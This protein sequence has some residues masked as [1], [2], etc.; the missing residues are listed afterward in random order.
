M[1][2]VH[3]LPPGPR[4]GLDGRININARG[5]RAFVGGDSSYRRAILA[6]AGA[7]YN[8]DPDEVPG[9]PQESMFNAMRGAHGMPYD[10]TRH[11][12]S[13]VMFGSEAHR[14]DNNGMPAA[15]VGEYVATGWFAD[16]IVDAAN[17]ALN[18]HPGRTARVQ[19]RLDVVILTGSAAAPGVPHYNPPLARINGVLKRVPRFIAVD[20]ETVQNLPGAIRAWSDRAS[21]EFARIIDDLPTNDSCRVMTHMLAAYVWATPV[22]SPRLRGRGLEAVGG[23][24]PKAAVYKIVSAETTALHASSDHGVLHGE[25]VLPP[26]LLLSKGLVM[27]NPL[28]TDTMC[29]VRAICMALDPRVYTRSDVYLPT[30]LEN[31]LQGATAKLHQAKKMASEVGL[32]ADLLHKRKAVVVRWE[33]EIASLQVAVNEAKR[34]ETERGYPTDLRPFDVRSRYVSVETELRKAINGVHAKMCFMNP[35]FR[36]RFDVDDVAVGML[37]AA[38]APS[39]HLQ[40]WGVGGADKICLLHPARVTLEHLRQGHRLVNLFI[41]YNHAS[42]IRSI[43]A[44]CNHR[45]V[46]LD[47]GTRVGKASSRVFCSMCG[48]HLNTGTIGS[49]WDIYNHQVRGCPSTAVLEFPL[50][51]SYGD[52]V[53]LGKRARIAQER[54]L[55]FAA[56][57]VSDTDASITFRS[58]DVDAVSLPFEHKWI[59]FHLAPPP[60]ER[61]CVRSGCNEFVSSPAKGSAVRQALYFMCNVRSVDGLLSE[62]HKVTPKRF[63]VD[64]VPLTPE[65][66]CHSCHLPVNGPSVWEFQAAQT[67]EYRDDGF[68]FDDY[69]G[70]EDAR[71]VAGAVDEE[72]VA[73]ADVSDVSSAPVRAPYV[74]HHCHA[75]GRVRLAHSDCNVLIIQ[76]CNR[77]VVEM[78]SRA[79]LAAIVEETC[80]RAFMDT[81]SSNTRPPE[82]SKRDGLVSRV[83]VSVRGSP[84]VASS[85][86]R[87]EWVRARVAKG[88][89][90]TV[91]LEESKSLTVPRVLTLVFRVS[92]T[93][94]EP[95]DGIIGGAK[96]THHPTDQVDMLA[97]TLLQK[98]EL[99]FARTKLWMLAFE[100]LTAYGCGCLYN[101]LHLSLAPGVTPTSFVNPDS[102]DSIG[103]MTRGGRILVG[104]RAEWFPCDYEDL[105]KRRLYFDLTSAYPAVLKQFKFPLLCHLDARAHDFSSN[106]EDGLAFVRS[107]DLHSDFVHRMEIEGYFPPELHASL[108]DFC[109]VYQRLEVFGRNMSAFQRCFMAT[110]SE[111]SVGVKNV[112][113]LFPVKDW[114]VFLRRAKILDSMGFVFTRIGVVWSTPAS[115]WARPFATMQEERRR[116]AYKSKV[117]PHMYTPAQRAELKCV[118]AVTKMVCNSVIGTFAKDN[119]RFTRLVSARNSPSTMPAHRLSVEEVYADSPLATGRRWVAGDLTLIE[120]LPKRTVH[121]NLILC[122]VFATEM[123]TDNLL[124]FWLRLRQE[125]PGVSLAYG[126]VDSLFVDV[127]LSDEYRAKGVVDVRHEVYAR[128]RHDVLD[129]SNVPDTSTFWTTMP[130]WLREGADALKLENAGK[131]KWVK[132]QTQ[133]V[134]W[135]EMVICGPNRYGFRVRQHPVDTPEEYRGEFTQSVLK[136]LPTDWKGSVRI[137]DFAADWYRVPKDD[138]QAFAANLPK[139][140]RFCTLGGDLGH[141]EEVEGAGRK[142]VV[143][144]GNRSCI[145]TRSGDSLQFPFGSQEPLAV[146]AVKGEVW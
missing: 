18:S 84:R 15:E 4:E 128:L 68:D 146:A 19:L 88:G 111:K 107:T 62:L 110:P 86:E 57:A 119:H 114:V 13:V 99:E 25:F 94:E 39:I 21:D 85:V 33:E 32:R 2:N 76:S 61:H 72:V 35:L 10:G 103:R 37:R 139:P 82:I 83:I 56:M 118:D 5:A 126:C 120:V 91:I 117:F 58:Y 63:D 52:R 26:A 127:E 59:P 115:D 38:L 102:L 74:Q 129:V 28:V 34:A 78:P 27:N 67:I 133:M 60:G 20:C 43:S 112:A 100:T 44:C 106:L 144:W 17:A 6:D 92:D 116:E 113:H 36:S 70:E 3:I 55:V 51:L 75:S 14:Y 141:V 123:A 9:R 140:A 1:S 122:N 30:L 125:F 64:P 65:S 42:A 96:L 23:R 53:Q 11:S 29:V 143:T 46:V 40:I 145:V 108:R 93:F 132:E 47:S 8:A 41:A 131:W 81:F 90:E 109:P 124:E 73:I 137:E 121:H 142:V 24:T 136:S 104:S 16:D 89:D 134:G 79:S 31:G 98:S 80:S 22:L 66:P 105:S 49:K 69:A 95:V 45:D 54:P 71:A 50:P 130:D 138:Q 87:S 12:A 7:I 77:L 135:S 101:T 97:S 48:F